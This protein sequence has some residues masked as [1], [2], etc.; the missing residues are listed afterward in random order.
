MGEKRKSVFTILLK[1]KGKKKFDKVEMF[2]S[3]EFGYY[4]SRVNKYRIRVNGK[5]YPKGKKEFFSKKQIMTL[6][7]GS[8]HFN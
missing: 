2:R 6:I 8:I 5:W 7:E 1:S 4:D 3:F